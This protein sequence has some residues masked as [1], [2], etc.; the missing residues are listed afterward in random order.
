MKEPR[1]KGRRK[2]PPTPGGKALDRLRQ[3]EQER[4]LEPSDIA[5]E[6]PENVPA[7]EHDAGK[8]KCP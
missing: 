7:E 6:C 4:G 3:F 2:P 5:R 1:K 8:D